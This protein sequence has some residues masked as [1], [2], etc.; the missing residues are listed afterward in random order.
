MTVPHGANSSSRYCGAQLPG[1][2]R[3]GP[4]MGAGWPSLSPEGQEG[5]CLMEGREGFQAE[6]TV[7][8]PTVGKRGVL[9]SGNLG[10]SSR[11][12]VPRKGRA[13]QEM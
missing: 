12:A 5:T 3:E 1:E 4:R 10:E 7:R 6:E 9:S 13:S 8:I 11:L 2:N